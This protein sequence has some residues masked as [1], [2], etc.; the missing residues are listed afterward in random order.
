MVYAFTLP[1]GHR[2]R[3]ACVMLVAAVVAATYRHKLVKAS[4][5]RAKPAADGLVQ[6]HN[7]RTELCLAG[8]FDPKERDVLV[9]DSSRP[10]TR[11]DLMELSGCAGS[12]AGGRR[13]DPRGTSRTGAGCGICRK[14]VSIRS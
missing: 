2:W 6:L 3:G 1:E 5:Q 4:V 9:C 7:L 13:A 10:S 8:S 14:R 11:T 12:L